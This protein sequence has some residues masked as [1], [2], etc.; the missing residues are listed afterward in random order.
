MNQIKKELKRFLVAG[1]SAVGTDLVSYYLLLSF[2]SHDVA[3][4]ISFL[5]GTVVAYIINKYWTFEKHEKSYKEVVKFSILYSV[6][7]GANV[8]TNKM[9]LEMTTI[10]F[11]AFL[12]ATGVS[13]I[14]N[15]IGQKWWVFK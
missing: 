9:V 3:K 6:T 11:L 5:L 8:M 4:G 12:V 15:F 10:V 13:T 7:F 14:L 1:L 2:L